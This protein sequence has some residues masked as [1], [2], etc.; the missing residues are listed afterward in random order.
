MYG[1]GERHGRKLGHVKRPRSC[2]RHY[3][4]GAADRDCQVIT[5]GCGGSRTWNSRHRERAAG[6]WRF[7]ATWRA[8]GPLLL[9]VQISAEFRS[10]PCRSAARPQRLNGGRPMLGGTALGSRQ[11]GGRSPEGADEMV[12]EEDEALK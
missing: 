10:P 9:I 11:R 6:H 3:A 2:G 12:L 7:V 8:W 4:R 1:K 5:A